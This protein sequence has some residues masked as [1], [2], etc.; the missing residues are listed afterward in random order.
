MLVEEPDQNNELLPTIVLALSQQVQNLLIR[1]NL[2]E[3]E[4]MVE[5]LLSVT[6]VIVRS[7][8][9]IYLTKFLMI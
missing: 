9:T 5:E 6:Q 7:Y 3:V 8:V 1:N 2:T 4:N